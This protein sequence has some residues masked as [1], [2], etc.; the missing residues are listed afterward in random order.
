MPRSGRYGAG[1][2]T[3]RHISQSGRA[4]PDRRLT[5]NVGSED[6]G[7][8][9]LHPASLKAA[10]P[11][12]NRST[13]ELWRSRRRPSGRSTPTWPRAWKTMLHY[14]ERPR[15]SMRQR[16]W[17]RAPKRS[18]RSTNESFRLV[19]GQVV[20][21]SA[22]GYKPTSS[23]PKLRSALP[24]TADI[25]APRPRSEHR[26]NSPSGQSI[27]LWTVCIEPGLG[28]RPAGGVLVAAWVTGSG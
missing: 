20:A 28:A 15:A 1:G 2:K 24:P 25:Q 8:P 12:P 13:S 23:R 7:Q 4:P 26:P 18:V 5:D 10:T 11:R 22:Y 27:P 6:G 17:R 3:W 14:S 16:G 19:H 9:A 21:T